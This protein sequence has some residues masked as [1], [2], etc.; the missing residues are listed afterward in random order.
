MIG[1]T[2]AAFAGFHGYDGVLNQLRSHYQHHAEL[3]HLHISSL[4]NKILQ[5]QASQGLNI[6][7]APEKTELNLPKI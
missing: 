3:R 7:A 1:L 6:D 5:T 2:R 4:A